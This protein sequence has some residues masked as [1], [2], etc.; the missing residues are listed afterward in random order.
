MIGRQSLVTGPN[1]KF[2]VSP[3]GCGANPNALPPLDKST[4]RQIA[5]KNPHFA[6]CPVLAGRNRGIGFQSLASIRVGHFKTRFSHSL[7]LCTMRTLL[8][9]TGSI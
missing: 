2:D 8:L 5:L 6:G 9:R 7:T 4:Q 3:G 1:I